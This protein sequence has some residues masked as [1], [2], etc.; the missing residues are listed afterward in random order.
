MLLS[1][2]DTSA[3][4]DTRASF[5]RECCWRRGS[6]RYVAPEGDRHKHHLVDRPALKTEEN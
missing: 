1:V 2:S 5:K 4:R 3:R 6:R